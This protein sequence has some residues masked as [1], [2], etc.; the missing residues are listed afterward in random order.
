ME[1]DKI[2][3]LL[4]ARESADQELEK[5]RTAVTILFS[6]IRGSTAYFEKYGDVQG[7][8]M[9]Q[10]HNNML[11]PVIEGVGGRVV[12]TIGDAIMAAFLDPTSGVQAAIGMQRALEDDRAKRSPEEQI[13]IKVGL[14]TGLGLLKDNDVFGDVVNAAA[15][16]QH[17]A[18]PDQILITD[19]LLDSAKALGVQCAEMGR[20]TMKGKDEPID[21]YAISWSASSNDQLIEQLQAQFDGKLKDAK[22]QHDELDQEFESAREQWRRDRRTLTE[23]ID[24]LEKSLERAKENARSQVSE[25]LQSEIRFQ[26]ES[27]VRARQQLEQDMTAAQAKWDTERNQLKAQIGLMQGSALESMERTNNPARLALAVREQ[28]ESRL[29]SAKQDW[30][31]QWDGE[32]RRLNAEIERLKKAGG[33]GVDPKKEAAKRALLERLGKIPAGAGGPGAKS[34]ADWES[35]FNEAKARWEA[36]RDQLLVIVQKLEREVQYAK[37]DLRGELLEEVRGQ[38]EPQ[39]A[40]AN[41]ERLRLDAELEALTAQVAE[42][43]QRTATRIGLLEQAIPEAQDAAKKQISAELQADFDAKLEESKRSKAKADRQ[44]QADF[45]DWDAERRKARK[46]IAKLEEDLKEA[47]EIAYKAQR[48]RPEKQE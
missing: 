3:E 27:A 44:Y 11:F 9:V 4:A 47:K 29:T 6:D 31:M 23:E 20:A 18:Q 32:R 14:H 13:H 36:E 5:M 12:K 46:Q 22:R 37:D 39:L 30:E 17:Q 41:R 2:E 43:R 19:V 1:K 42:E 35:E 16:V 15:R 24:T 21:L 28:L 48:N 8:A 45:E 26:L 34:A 7:L 25:D 38:F 33:G 40:E 10:R